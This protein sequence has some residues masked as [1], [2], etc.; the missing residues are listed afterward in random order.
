MDDYKPTFLGSVLKVIACT[1]NYNDDLDAYEKGVIEPTQQLRKMSEELADV[2]PEK[3]QIREILSQLAN[4]LK[5][6]QVDV[7]EQRERFKEILELHQFENEF[8]EYL[9]ITEQ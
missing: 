5:I 9:N 8:S 2:Q 3:G 4:I 7:T 1:P 6:K